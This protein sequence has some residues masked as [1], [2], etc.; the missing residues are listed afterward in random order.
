MAI[1]TIPSLAPLALCSLILTDRTHLQSVGHITDIRS[2]SALGIVQIIKVDAAGVVAP[3]HIVRITTGVCPN[4]L[5]VEPLNETTAL[6]CAL[7][8]VD[9]HLG[10]ASLWIVGVERHRPRVGLH[11]AAILDA[12]IRAANVNIT[13]RLGGVSNS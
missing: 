3:E 4:I 5:I 1:I 7:C 9:D 13:A 2:S 6:C 8:T 10:D 12:V 11:Q